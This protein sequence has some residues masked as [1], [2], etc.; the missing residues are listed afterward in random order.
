M[1]RVLVQLEEAAEAGQEAR[2][3]GGRG[4]PTLSPTPPPTLPRRLTP[5]GAVRGGSRSDGGDR[6]RQSIGGGGRRR[7]SRRRREEGREEEVR[8][9][10]Q[11]RRHGRQEE[12]EQEEEIRRRRFRREERQEESRQEK[13]HEHGVTRSGTRAPVLLDVVMYIVFVVRQV[14][15]R[16]RPACGPAGADH[17]TK[18]QKRAYAGRQHREGGHGT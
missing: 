15:G 17:S 12:G 14:A 9:E 2:P 6:H 13:R 3:R 11:G 18:M 16:R 5:V 10:E 1:T 7:W 8:Q 4:L